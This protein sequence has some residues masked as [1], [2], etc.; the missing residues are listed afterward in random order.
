MKIPTGGIFYWDLFIPLFVY[1]GSWF[2]QPLLG[3]ISE[4]R[5]PDGGTSAQ[6][7]ALALS[8]HLGFLLGSWQ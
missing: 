3:V 4:L 5:L 1:E 7:K 6:S 2:D 8:P